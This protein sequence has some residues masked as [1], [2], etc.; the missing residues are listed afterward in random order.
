MSNLEKLQQELNKMRKD[1]EEW[2]KQFNASLDKQK[3]KMREDNLKF[4]LEAT[5][6]RLEREQQLA[7]FRKMNF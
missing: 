3:A 4:Q 2:E 6:L 7:N 5:K 1:N